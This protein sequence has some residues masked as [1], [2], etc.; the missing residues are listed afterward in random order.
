MKFCLAIVGL[1]AFLG[2]GLIHD[3]YTQ[4]T[5]AP[6]LQQTALQH[7]VE[8]ES[9]QS[10]VSQIADQISQ[11]NQE[12]KENGA[13]DIE[14]RDIDTI[15]KGLGTVTK[16]DM[17]KV[18]NSLQAAADSNDKNK[19]A[20]AL[21]AAYQG[22]QGVLAKVT[23]I[24]A[25]LQK[26]QTY[27]RLQSELQDLLKRQ[28]G[29]I[30]LSIAVQKIGSMKVERDWKM[31]GQAILTQEGLEPR[32]NSLQAEVE[33][34]ISKL[35]P[36][37]GDALKNDIEK[38]DFAKLTSEAADVSIICYRTAIDGEVA[39]SWDGGWPH[40]IQYESDIRDK[41]TALLLL[42]SSKDAD[43]ALQTASETLD[44][45][46]GQQQD[47]MGATQSNSDSKEK[48][49]PEAD[50]KIRND[51]AD[52]Q[53]GL[54]D[55]TTALS[56][57]LASLAPSAVQPLGAAS[58]HMGASSGALVIN[59][60]NT[61][62]G[63]QQQAIDALKLAK[64][65]LLKKMAEMASE[66]GQSMDSAEDQLNQAAQS[67]DAAADANA[68]AQDSLSQG[69][70]ANASSQ[71]SDSSSDLTR[72][73]NTGALPDS[74]KQAVDRAQTAIREARDQAG[75]DQPKPAGDAS[76]RAADEIAKAQA[77]VNKALA[78]MAGTSAN[79]HNTDN[80]AGGLGDTPLQKGRTKIAAPD[81]GGPG[82]IGYVHGR[83]GKAAEVTEM[84]VQNREA[85]ASQPDES[86]PSEFSSMVGQYYKNLANTSTTP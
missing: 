44:R 47:L 52:Q 21:S 50:A 85:I 34:L 15:L 51:L 43:S 12:L 40:A 17:G 46:I 35:P 70:E 25:R 1:T 4:E 54:Q 83:F 75:K 26:K 72:A 64:E 30:R 57:T 13:S 16:E 22:Q 41:L 82:N 76:K 20:S 81:G 24:A 19:Q 36:D 3:G 28:I 77:E 39:H 65:N 78:D 38:I 27:E 42:I 18:I 45:L 23:L 6:D 58:N 48:K 53:D 5:E 67:L 31:R 32:I 55:S 11:I 49:N 33:L 56:T 29:N 8:Q 66:G 74:A 9:I 79:E 62:L 10:D 59:D 14:I 60:S 61:S 37:E 80:G 7:R 2:A 69:N 84:H 68:Q 86:V 71:L 63:A 73:A